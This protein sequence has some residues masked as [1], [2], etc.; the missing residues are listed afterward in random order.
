MEVNEIVEHIFKT[1]EFKQACKKYANNKELAEELYSEFIKVLLEQPEDTKKA[2]KEGY[3]NFHCVSIINNIWG[4][5]NRYSIIRGT[6]SPLFVYSNTF[7]IPER[8]G[9][10][11]MLSPEE[12]FSVPTP[13]YDSEVDYKYK[14]ACKIIEDEFNH[15]N[16]DRMYKAR[17]FYYSTY[18][19]DSVAEFSRK[20]GI[21]YMNVFMT[22]KRFKDYLKKKLK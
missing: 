8:E 1:G 12:Y 18:K 13:T 16:K 17:V 14:K 9:E 21:P 20:S 4:K 3:F 10:E 22:Y 7:E 5:R 2:W 11:G 19:Y 15:E 6:T